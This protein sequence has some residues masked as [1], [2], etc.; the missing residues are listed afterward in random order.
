MKKTFIIIVNVVIMAAILIFV[1]LYS[2]S[3]SRDSYQRQIEHFEDTTV[4]MERVTGNYL[5]SEQ[6][7]C[8]IW[9]HYINN[10]TMTMEEAADYIRSSHVLKNTSAHLI[11][12]DTLR[13]LST[14]P[15]QGTD[16]DY[17][18]SYERVDLLKNVDW[19]DEIGKSINITRAFT[20][21]MNGEQSLAFCN[22]VRLHDP[23]SNTSGDAVLLRVIPISVLEQKWVFP[24]T[25]LMNAELS[26][27]DANGD[28][29]LKGDSFKNSNFFEFYKSY[30]STD[31][32]TSGEL[33]D[34]IT[35]STGSVSMI[36]S[37]EQECILAF[38]P[39][40]ATAGWTL[41]GLVPA[42]DL[43]T[44]TENWLL[45]GVVSAGLLILFLSDLL[46]ILYFNKR[47]QI[48]AREAESANKAKTDFLS[49]M[50]HDIRTPMNAI[51]GLT[52]IAEK[53]SGMW[54]QQG[55]ASGKSVL[56]AITCLH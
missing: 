25:D 20:N 24:Q 23:E 39:V 30:N 26:M 14:R 7:I 12:L 44:D 42:K 40:S 17:A 1:V 43:H 32:E 13:G 5:E 8:D 18:V 36:N 52:T 31:P 50:S 6:R 29:I 47:L 28:Y 56:P 54:N 41:L 33:F 19:I 53:N 15:K 35:S 2:R 10:K 51:I 38:T 34:R 4:T 21:P 22:I 46:Y 3:E 49:T 45:I 27:I 48:A 37:H 55:K 9:A 16:D 11:S